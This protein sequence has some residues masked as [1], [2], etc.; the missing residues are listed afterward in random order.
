[1]G[2]DRRAR[3][4]GRV[5]EFGARHPRLSLVI[6]CAALTG[7]IAVCGYQLSYGTY[8]G[9]AWV[10]AASAGLATAAGLAVAVL[11][12]GRRHRPVAGGLLIGWLV[13]A[14][15]SA[16]A[17]RYPFPQGPYGGV[18]AFFNGLHAALLGYEAVTC[19]AIVALFA[20]PL[21]HPGARTRNQTERAGYSPGRSG[22]PARLR[23][24]GAK[25]AV[26]RAG[27]LIAA[28]GTVMWLSLNGD[29]EVDLTSACQAL[30][31]LPDAAHRRQRQP[32][33]TA[34][35]TVNGIVEVDVSPKALTTLAS[36][37]HRP[38]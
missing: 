31:T 17:V 14:L 35:A 18:Q 20:Y 29:A 36:S 4:L 16:S 38:H 2:S 32:R 34:L 11:I 15:A 1:L 21:L 33:T 12:S 23:F 13:L 28:N 37:L 7:V 9:R 10:I 26:W 8:L 27:S 5:R 22:L 19:T 24:P 6:A 25:P 3:R 30:P